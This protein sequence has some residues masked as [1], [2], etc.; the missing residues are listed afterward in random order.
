MI[1]STNACAS[2]RIDVSVIHQKFVGPQTGLDK[3]AAANSAQLIAVFAAVETP[4]TMQKPGKISL[5]GFG[6]LHSGQISRSANPSVNAA[7]S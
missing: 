2:A 1:S 3:P 7:R 4:A 5:P 6:C